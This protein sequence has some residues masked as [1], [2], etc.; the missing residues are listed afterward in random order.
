[1]KYSFFP[2]VHPTSAEE[3]DDNDPSLRMAG[4][5]MNGLQD[6]LDI[7]CY[8]IISAINFYLRLTVVDETRKKIFGVR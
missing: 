6:I 7:F 3:Q 8:T 5:F 4:K 1:M 2:R